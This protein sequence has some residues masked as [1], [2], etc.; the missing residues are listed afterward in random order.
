MKK[1]LIAD[2]EEILRM[3]I[4]DT[5]E[6]LGFEIHE[7]EN[8]KQAFE[9]LMET[10]YDLLILDYMMPFMTGIDV[11][12]KLPKERKDKIEIVMLT[13]KTQEADRE[14]MIKAGADFFMPKPFSPMDLISIIERIK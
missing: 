4:F 8:G 9:K 7:A 5:I 11:L 14:R 10:D 2:D 1:I 13:A 3:L 6:D 12:E